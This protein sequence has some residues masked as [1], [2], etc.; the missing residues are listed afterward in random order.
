MNAKALCGSRQKAAPLG[1][2]AGAE[3]KWLG[4]PSVLVG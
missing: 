1:C 3:K 2:K 4:M